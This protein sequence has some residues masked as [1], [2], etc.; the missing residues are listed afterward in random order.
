MS[1]L[2]PFHHNRVKI[3]TE[4]KG[5]KSTKSYYMDSIN[6][7]FWRNNSLLPFPDV[8]ENNRKQIEIVSQKEKE[9]RNKAKTSQSDCIYIY[10]IL[11]IFI[12]YIYL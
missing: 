8:V 6:D 2:L 5:V 10:K 12:K 4:D 7:E 1:D 9:V 11:L 3:I